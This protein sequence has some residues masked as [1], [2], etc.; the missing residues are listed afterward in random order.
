MGKWGHR[1]ITSYHG[2]SKVDELNRPSF[3]QCKNKYKNKSQAARDTTT[4]LPL[5]LGI[6]YSKPDQL[7]FY[8]VHFKK[9]PARVRWRVDKL[10]KHLPN[11][12]GGS[13]GKHRIL[14]NII[15]HLKL[16]LWNTLFNCNES[17][18][19]HIGKDYKHKQHF[20]FHFYCLCIY[21][22]FSAPWI[23]N[24]SENW[25]QTKASSSF[26]QA[27]AARWYSVKAIVSSQTRAL[28]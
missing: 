3:W 15:L 9:I 28:V 5:I 25:N 27:L 2:R 21:R 11:R 20:S 14:K 6:I 12:K 24:M 4:K 8:K 10:T 17:N 16:H 1:N 26:Y 13:G 19:Y 23:L 18:S 22:P 7:K